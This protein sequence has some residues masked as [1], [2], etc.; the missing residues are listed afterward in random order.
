MLIFYDFVLGLCLGTVNGSNFSTLRI[1]GVLQRFGIAYFFVACMHIFLA[2]S[3]ELPTQG[4]YARMLMDLHIIS[5]EWIVIFGIT[6]L[7][8]LIVFKF[9]VPGCPT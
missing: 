3:I 5:R 2:P 9:P 4:R 8:L 6:L 1:F 7:N